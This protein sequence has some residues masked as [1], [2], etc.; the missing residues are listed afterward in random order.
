MRG[1][2]VH[3]KWDRGH[4]VRYWGPSWVE[5]LW[6]CCT[7]YG[8][9]NVSH[10]LFYWGASIHRLGNPGHQWEV[11]LPWPHG[12]ERWCC[13][14]RYYNHLV[15]IWVC[16]LLL[17]LTGYV[18]S[19]IWGL[20]SSVGTFDGGSLRSSLEQL[21]ETWHKVVYRLCHFSRLRRTLRG[22]NLVS[23]RPFSG[24]GSGSWRS[25]RRPHGRWDLVFNSCTS[26]ARLDG[27]GWRGHRICRDMAD[28]GREDVWQRHS[29]VRVNFSRCCWF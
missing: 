12:L 21:Y 18:G 3:R 10:K 6:S 5:S 29:W 4:V 25:S 13:R 24:R 27:Q 15:G 16:L 8:G 28:M 20:E 1:W 2:Q 17:Y 23:F 19:Y 26:R 7:N 14:M 22:L 11:V 9:I